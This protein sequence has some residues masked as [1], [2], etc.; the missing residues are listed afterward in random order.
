MLPC[1][2]RACYHAA[3]RSHSTPLISFQKTLSLQQTYPPEIVV[4]VTPNV[5]ISKA[6][7]LLCPALCTRILPIE[8]WPAPL[9]SI[10]AQLGQADTALKRTLDDHCPGWTKLGIF[11][12]QQYDTILYIDCDCLVLKDVSSLLERNKV[13]TESE[14]LIAAAPD[15]L[16]PHYFNT[17]VM[18]VRPSRQVFDTMQRHASLLTTF[19]GSDTGFLNAYFPTWFTEFPPQARLPVGYNA[20]QAMFDQT[21][22]TATTDTSTDTNTTG[23]STFW[24]VQVAGSDLYIV[25]YSNPVKPWQVAES[26]SSSSSA[27]KNSLQVLWKT[28][29]QKSK[30]FLLRYQKERAKEEQQ[31]Q[32]EQE[33]LHRQRQ[34]QAAAAAKPAGTASNSTAAQLHPKQ[35]HKL[36]TQRFKELRAQGKCTK[37]AMKQARA[38]LQPSDEVERDV[39]SQVAAMFGMR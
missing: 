37:D 26:S 33:A 4:L 22:E 7:Q 25:H 16:P 32:L 13:Y 14:A 31:L 39:G 27:S 9:K 17:G 10:D 29:H 28:W 2:V 18:V 30:N 20:Q 11:S 34:A 36:V 23:T 21:M 19:D 8:E 12:L 15:I 35:I 3:A 5:S 38:E 1:L 24:D 6:Y